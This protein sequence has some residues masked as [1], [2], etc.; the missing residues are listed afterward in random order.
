[1]PQ[2][3]ED[4]S[5]ALKDEFSQKMQMESQVMFS[6]STKRFWSFTTT[7]EMF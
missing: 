5:G 1:M 6:K 4:Q 7:E 3:G 2:P